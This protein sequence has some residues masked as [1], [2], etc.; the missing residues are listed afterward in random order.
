[1]GLRREQAKE[2]SC[3]RLVTVDEDKEALGAPALGPIIPFWL[4]E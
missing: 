2:D 4:D 3:L 1:M